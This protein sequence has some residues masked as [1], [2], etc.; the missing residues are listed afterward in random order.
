MNYGDSLKRFRAKARHV[1]HEGLFM[2]LAL[3]A[4]FEITPRLKGDL[5]TQYLQVRCRVA[6]QDVGV[7]V[8]RVSGHL[9][10]REF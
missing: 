3:T 10:V 5:V 4:G 1:F 6:R 7:V 2:I 8:F 9:S